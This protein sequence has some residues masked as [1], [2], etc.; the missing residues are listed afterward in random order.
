MSKILTLSGLHFTDCNVAV[1]RAD[2]FQVMWCKDEIM[3]G[4]DEQSQCGRG[5]G[6]AGEGYVHGLR[7]ESLGLSPGSAT[8]WMCHL[9]RVTY[10]LMTSLLINKMSTYLIGLDRKCLKLDLAD[11]RIFTVPGRRSYVCEDSHSQM[12]E[13]HLK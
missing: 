12:T 9:G 13:I 1:T 3:R 10:F 8:G 6:R 2:P 11:N 7:S 5:R 4:Q